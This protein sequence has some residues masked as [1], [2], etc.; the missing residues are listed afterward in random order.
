MNEHQLLGLRAKL[1]LY[2]A[3]IWITQGKGG[4]YEAE[5]LIL[6]DINAGEL[7]ANIIRCDDDDAFTEITI[8]R[9]DLDE[10]LKARGFFSDAGQKSVEHEEAPIGSTERNT[11]LTIIA[12]LC[13]HS[14]IKHQDR[15]AAAQITRLTEEIG[16]VVSDDTIRRA[17]SKIPDALEFRTK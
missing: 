13:H 10:W 17:L 1:T 12:A 15:G 9:S 6:E 2:E 8:K 5:K 7:A 3:S 11:L 14:K 16:A 4:E